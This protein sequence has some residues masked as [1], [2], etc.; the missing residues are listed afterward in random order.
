MRE[1]QASEIVSMNS[2]GKDQSRIR[3]VIIIGTGFS[4]LGLAIGLKREGKIDFVVL[5]RGHDVGGT[6]RDNTY[7]GA[8]CDIPSHLYSYSF[9][10]NPNW[11]SVYARQQEIFDYLRETADQENIRPHICFNTNVLRANWDDAVSAWVVQTETGSYRARSLVS[12]AGHLSDPAFPDIDGLHSFAG[13]VI[14]S[15]RWDHSFQPE[16]QRIAVIGTGASAVQI[17]PELAK[18]AATLTIFQRS[19][20]YIVP[21]RDTAFTAAEKGMFARMPKTAQLLRNELFWFNEGRFLQRRRVP[22]FIAVVSAM[23]QG[24]LE[25]QVND[26]DLKRKVTPDYEVGCKRI[27]LS[28][29][30]Y[31][32]LQQSNVHLE[33]SPIERITES[34]LTCRDGS[35]HEVDALILATGF[36]ATDLPIAEVIFGRDG[37]RLAD[38]WRDRPRAFA[39]ASMSGYPNLF[40]MLGP[41]TGLGAGSMVYMAETQANYIRG[42]LN[43]IIDNGA[44]I[45]PSLEAETTY[46]SRI[47]ERS[48][49]TV[50]VAG[51]CKSWYLHKD[52][53]KLTALWPDFMRQ[54]RVENG[55]FTPTGYDVRESA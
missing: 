27:L 48:E 23:A 38:H 32:A 2:H 25:A 14:H 26:P 10:P 46:V 37:H 13:K 17:V 1:P 33:T 47:D 19:A 22:S 5:E 43:Y 54:F 15:A 44:V 31:P 53:G 6:W 40:M 21:R 11:S 52:S 42:A 41:N 4:G 3:D 51:G 9:R 12:A 55:T 20:P 39:S 18:T 24:H 49:G 16:G 28:N 50:W 7:P 34:G 29:D 35:A 30:Y 36:E 8:A 45:E